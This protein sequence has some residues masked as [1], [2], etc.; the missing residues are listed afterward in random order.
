MTHPWFVAVP[1]HYYTVPNWKCLRRAGWHSNIL[2]SS[3]HYGQFGYQVS[4]S[5]VIS[6]TGISDFWEDG[7]SALWIIFRLLLFSVIKVKCVTANYDFNILYELLVCNKQSILNRYI[8]RPF[9]CFFNA[10]SII[11]PIE[12]WA[13]DSYSI[14]IHLCF[15][16]VVWYYPKV[17]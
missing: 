15:F 1:W 4:S 12:T 11:F 17:L 8:F 10:L 3:I 16:L 2:S 7:V 6:S 13:S 14:N 9:W 5:L